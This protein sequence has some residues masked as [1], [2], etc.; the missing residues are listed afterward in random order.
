MPNLDHRV[1]PLARV[2]LDAQPPLCAAAR[3]WAEAR[4]TA[5]G[6]FA[7]AI[8]AGVE[9]WAEPW[10]PHPIDFKIAATLKRLRTAKDAAARALLDAY[11]SALTQRVRQAIPDEFSDYVTGLFAVA[12]ASPDRLWRQRAREFNKAS[13]TLLRVCPEC[14]KVFYA[15]DPRGEFCSKKCGNRKRGRGRPPQKRLA[16]LWAQLNPK[17]KRGDALNLWRGDGVEEGQEQNTRAPSGRRP[18][19]DRAFARAPIV[20]RRSR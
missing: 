17:A 8:H 6:V 3:T 7:E 1:L 10:Q 2:I 18:T 11:S 12:R 20:R 16:K 5:A 9:M 19:T 13:P 15:T 14:F 4:W